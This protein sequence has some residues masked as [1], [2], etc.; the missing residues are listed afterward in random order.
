MDIN[1]EQYRVFY[2]VGRC[3]SV[4]AAAK[5]LCVSQP[6][7]SQAV[8]Q[9]ERELGSELFVRTP[10][11]VRLTQAGHL[12]S[13]YAQEILALSHTSKERLKES[14][15]TSVIHFGIGCRSFL[16]LGLVKPALRQLRSDFPLLRPTL[17]LVSSPSLESML[18]DGDVQVIFTF[19]ETA[20]KRTT[21]RELLRQKVVC[22]CGKDHP[23]AAY[24][25][26]TVQQLRT[27]ECLAASPPHSGPAAIL[28]LQGRIITG[29]DQ[30]RICFCDGLETLYALVEAGYAFA[31]TTDLPDGRSPDICAI[32]VAGV[33]AISYG[34]AYR[35]GEDHPMLRPFLEQMIA[36]FAAPREPEQ[37]DGA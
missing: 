15:Q 29:R 13:Q 23:F 14:R 26:L 31:V 6:A 36:R 2:Q 28:E 4:T 7:V 18:E 19:Q 21:Y 17:R 33:P 20:P 11:G 30:D 22:I 12:F 37:E 8:R 24:D 10:K 5:K 35:V 3:G 34:V 32:P 27:G 9:L 1:L 16:E 25:T